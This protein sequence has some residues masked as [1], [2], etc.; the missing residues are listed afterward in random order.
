MELFSNFNLNKIAFEQKIVQDL[1]FI[2]NISF[3]KITS[4]SGISRCVIGGGAYNSAYCASLVSNLKIK[5]FSVVGKDFPISIIKDRGID[6]SGIHI[7]EEHSNTFIINEQSG[8]IFFE[9]N[10]PLEFHLNNKEHAKHVHISCRKGIRYPYLCLKNTIYHSSST[11]VISSSLK[12]KI[13]E[14]KKCLKAINMLFLNNYEYD[15]LN[16]CLDI[17]T[18]HL[19]PKV[20]IFI[21]KGK[22]GVTVKKHKKEISFPGINI[23]KEDIVSTTG[24]G[25]AFIGGFLGSYYS[26]RPFCESLAIG[27]SIATLSIQ[28]FGISH[29]TNKLSVL[30]EYFNKLMPIYKQKEHEIYEFLQER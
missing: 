3:D 8:D 30:D 17:E 11:D 18:A 9:N 5:V 12:E 21:T 22:G 25:D 27:V 14:I 13:D 29:V 24:S 20:I 10:Q 16:K 1:L 19:F 4:R 2:G 6:V 15:M 28:D 26:S 7:V 23:K